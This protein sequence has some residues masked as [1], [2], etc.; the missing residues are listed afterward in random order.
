MVN[1]NWRTQRV[2]LDAFQH[3]SVAAI[4]AQPPLGQESC[5]GSFPGSL[6]R[7]RQ[8]GM[9]AAGQ[10]VDRAQRQRGSSPRRPTAMVSGRGKDGKRSCTGYTRTQADTDLLL[11][12]TY[13]GSSVSTLVLALHMVWALPALA[14]FAQ[15]SNRDPLP[16]QMAGALS[17]TIVAQPHQG[18]SPAPVGPNSS[19]SRPGA[20]EHPTATQ[21]S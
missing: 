11:S 14:E 12:L 4:C 3:I 5:L 9:N 19:L 7:C 15:V 16:I 17:R 1:R 2:L 13:G 21:T 6:Q 20:R 10:L 8:A 18:E